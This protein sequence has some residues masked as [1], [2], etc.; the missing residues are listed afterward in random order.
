MSHA[1]IIVAPLN[2]LDRVVAEE[3]PE[4]VLSIISPELMPE[5]P[6]GFAAERHH[7]IP[8]HDISNP[9]PGMTIPG[10]RHAE[11]VL[12]VAE[13]WSR[14]GTYV[15]HCWAGVSRSGAAAL[16]TLAALYPGRE[17]EVARYMR[18]R[19]IFAQPNRALIRAG[20]EVLG[21]QGR[22][23]RAVEAMSPA[24]LTAYGTPYRMC[25]S[26]E[27][28]RRPQPSASSAA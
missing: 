28:P 2:H 11:Q 12:R 15:V 20:D 23:V 22:L 24:D 4:Q 25:T 14:S 27:P 10:L 13:S 16:L 3:E 8:V 7:R 19:S 6:L 26:L 17:D 18:S 21:C 5:T 1:H 9:E